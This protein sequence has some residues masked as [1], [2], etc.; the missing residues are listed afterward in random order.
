MV[1]YWEKGLSVHEIGKLLNCSARTIN[2]RMHECDIPV[3]KPGLPVVDISKEDLYKLYIEK[4]L[5]SR[6]IAKIYRCAYSTI[7]ARIKKFGFPIRT[8]SAAHIT[9]RRA[10]FSENSKEKA[11]LIGF[12]TG[13]L[14]VRKAHKNS[15]TISIDCGSTKPRQISLIKSLFSPYGRVWISKPSKSGKTQIECGVDETF[16][17][18][19]KKYDKFPAWALKRRT[20]ILSLLAGFIDADGSFF[21]F[22]VKCGKS[23]AFSIGNYNKN[24]LKQMQE[25]LRNLGIKS[26]LFMGTK[27]GYQGKDG[28]LSNN[29][30]WILTV[31]RKFDLYRFTN[32]IK[33]YLK[34]KDKI[35]DA[36]RVI[37][38]INE[39]NRRYGYIG[40]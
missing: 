12:A 22:K 2:I 6:K 10:P 26:R 15:E 25:Q 18:L 33:P 24:L 39:R 1:L 40:M 19:L 23:S 21:L 36:R 35:Q 27:R 11:Y 8:L 16:S 20:L 38:N 7:D 9:T 32:L 37:N 13:D 30:Y 34:H 3:R 14:R 28:Y 4:G 5:S 31:N 29:D 17:F